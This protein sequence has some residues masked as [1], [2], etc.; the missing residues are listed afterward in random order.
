MLERRPRVVAIGIGNRLRAG[1]EGFRRCDGALAA[2][3]IPEAS[4]GKAA[5]DG[6]CALISRLVSCSD[7]CVFSAEAFG[8]AVACCSPVP[9]RCPAFFFPPRRPDFPVGLFSTALNIANSS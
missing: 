7:S 3:S 5:A 9:V 8:T 2:I 1:L 4:P 6:T